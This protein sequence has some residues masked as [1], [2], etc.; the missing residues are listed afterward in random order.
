[1]AQKFSSDLRKN[2][3]LFWMLLNTLVRTLILL[4][5]TN[6]SQSICES[7]DEHLCVCV[8]VS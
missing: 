1:M 2:I 4:T 7:F 5:D 8:L 3:F 6:I